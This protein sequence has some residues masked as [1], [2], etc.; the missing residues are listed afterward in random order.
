MSVSP[1]QAAV[2]KQLDYC[3]YCPKMCRHACP[4]GNAS[5]HESYTPQSKM[6]RLNELRKARPLVG[7]IGYRTAPRTDR[8][9]DGPDFKGMR[10]LTGTAGLRT[11]SAGAALNTD[12]HPVIEFSAASSHLTRGHD[13]TRRVMKQLRGAW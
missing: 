13:E 5:G 2:A 3:T 7:L 9:E 11:W 10:R 12:D 8:V 1:E 4:V 6:N